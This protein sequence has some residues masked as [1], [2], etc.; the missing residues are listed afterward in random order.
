ML[1]SL[2]TRPLSET[3]VSA[4]RAQH[5]GVVPLT[6]AGSG[7][8]DDAWVVTVVITDSESERI[9]LVGF[10][11]EREGWTLVEQWQGADTDFDVVRDRAA[12]W[13]ESTYPDSD[14]ATPAELE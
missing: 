12:T 5:G 2:P 7:D 13:L 4:L 8:E 9:H 11:D 6:Y 1:E 3:E 14:P 10:E